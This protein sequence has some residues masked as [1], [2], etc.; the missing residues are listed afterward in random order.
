MSQQHVCQVLKGSS[1]TNE[2]NIFLLTIAV[3]LI[4]AEMC[5]AEMWRG[6]KFCRCVTFD[7]FCE[8]KSFEC[9]VS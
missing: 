2:Q 4:G 8:K 5:A 9:F 1:I 6:L 7:N 3:N